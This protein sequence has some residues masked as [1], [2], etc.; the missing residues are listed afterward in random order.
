MSD[1]NCVQIS[2]DN[3]P[4][5]EAA[6]LANEL[7]QDLREAAA[8]EITRKRDRPDSQDFG[9]TLVVLF[10]TPVAIVLAKAV[11]NFLQRH[12][13]ASISITKDGAVVAKNLESKDAAK[14][15]E[16]FARKT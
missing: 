5:G 1:I 9:A 14:I 11:S 3:C 12:S 6:Q 13:G 16:A 8:A 15:A 2:F 10:G 7:E 4:A